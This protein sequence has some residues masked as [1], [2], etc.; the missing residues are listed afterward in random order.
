M[1]T[2]HVPVNLTNPRVSSLAGN[3]FFS[4]LALTN[5]DAGHW[6]FVKDV[7]GKVYGT[8]EVPPNIT[9]TPNAALILVTAYNATSGIA[10]WSVK[11]KD[12]ADGE[13]LN[14]SFT[15]ETAQDITVPATAYLR[16][17]VT[18][19]LTNAPAGSDLLLVEVFHEGAHANDTVAVNSLVFGAFLRVDV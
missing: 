3:A 2:I 12:P 15:S 18:F 7:D 14:A 11:S 17:D 6:E 4:I 19:I 9:G 10:R 8:V 1:P 5:W 13:T 16:K